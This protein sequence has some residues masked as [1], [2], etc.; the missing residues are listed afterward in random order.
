MQNP[1]KTPRLVKAMRRRVHARGQQRV[2][3]PA[4]D[5]SRGQTLRKT[6]LGAQCDIS[7]AFSLAQCPT[8]RLTIGRPNDGENCVAEFPAYSYMQSEVRI[9][10]I[11]SQTHRCLLHS[12]Q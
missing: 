9:T 3:G 7:P 6:T 4:S 1:R 2:H 8:V 5:S 11:P 12:R 10:P